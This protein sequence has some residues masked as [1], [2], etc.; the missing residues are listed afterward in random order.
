MKKLAVILFTVILLTFSAVAVADMSRASAT[1]RS[2][3]LAKWKA[4][5]GQGYWK[6]NAVFVEYCISTGAAG[7]DTPPQWDCAVHVLRRHGK[8]IQW[9]HVTLGLH[10]KTGAT[11]Y[12]NIDCSVPP[13]AA[14]DERRSVR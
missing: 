14:L 7:Q 6:C 12:L 5:C 10:H 8:K 2:I 9:C 1:V 13:P 11:L 3:E 4:A